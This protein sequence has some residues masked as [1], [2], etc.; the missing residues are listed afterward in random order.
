M[1]NNKLARVIS[2]VKELEARKALY[3]E[4]DQ[5]IQ[6]LVAEGFKEAIVDEMFLTLK[7]NFA[8]KNTGWTAAAVK[9]F[10]IE[11]ETKEERE[12]RLAKTAKKMKKA[13]GEPPLG[14]GGV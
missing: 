14:S 6:E 4:L 7:D 11:I 13:S 5:L 3:A 2:I 9:R 10:E 8:D 12:A 1:E